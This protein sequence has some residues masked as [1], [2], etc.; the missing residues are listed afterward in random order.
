[1]PEPEPAPAKGPARSEGQSAY[2][3]PILTFTVVLVALLAGI[4]LFHHKSP[5]SSPAEAAP[6]KVEQAPPSQ[7]PSPAPAPASVPAQSKP[8]PPPVANTQGEVAQ[9]V[10]PD[11]PQSAKNT[12]TGTLKVVVRVEV[13]ASGKVTEAKLITAGPSKYFAGLALSAARRWEFTPPQVNG[14]PSAS[15]WTLRFH[16]KRTSTQV[17][18]ER[19]KG[20]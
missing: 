5:Q 1:V 19:A 8:T 12:I 14:Q 6:A 7:A 10:V 18:P 4:R 20:H 13:D 11:V 3:W 15:A 2:R 17:S 16:F 9:Q